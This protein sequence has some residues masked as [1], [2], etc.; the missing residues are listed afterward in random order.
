MDP[1]ENPA[2]PEP[3][4][5]PAPIALDSP[6]PAPPAPPAPRERSPS[7]Y[8][9]RPR[10]ARSYANVAGHTDL[11][12]CIRA[13][14]AK[15]KHL[16]VRFG[17]SQVRRIRIRDEPR[18]AAHGAIVR[19]SIAAPALAT[20]TR[21]ANDPPDSG[22]SPPASPP[23]P[24]DDDLPL[25]VGQWVVMAD[26]GAPW[27]GRIHEVLRDGQL[28]IFLYELVAGSKHLLE[29]QPVW[30]NPDREFKLSPTQPPGLWQ[31]SVYLGHIDAMVSN[32]P[33][34]EPPANR[35]LRLPKL[36]ARSFASYVQDPGNF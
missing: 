36:A 10:A 5:A 1:R 27:I 6:A 19:D 35:P 23:S 17:W 14:S 31:K 18:K 11:K 20:A 12:S 26:A 9:L 24:A 30:I 25:A 4:V 29:A 34:V 3:A 13:P 16:R 8:S 2:A 32:H 7:P 21:L 33:F 22:P 15:K 28:R